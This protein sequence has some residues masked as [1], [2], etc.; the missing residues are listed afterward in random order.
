MKYSLQ[1]LIAIYLPYMGTLAIVLIA[2]SLAYDP[3]MTVFL[4][5]MLP[6]R[7]KTWSWFL[8]CL[9]EEFRSLAIAL[10]IAAPGW[11][12]HVIALDLVNRSLEEVVENTLKR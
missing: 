4:Y 8:T 3:T 11:Q 12:I 10:S 9:L 7:W 6:Q 5:S 2:L 1:D